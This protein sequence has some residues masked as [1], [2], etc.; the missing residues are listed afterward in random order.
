VQQNGVNGVEGLEGPN[1][2]LVSPDG[3]HVYVA[4]FG[5]DAVAV[6]ARD[7]ATGYLTYVQHQKRGVGGIQGLGSPFGL[8]M[9]PDRAGLYAVGSDSFSV[10][11]FARDTSTGALALVEEKF[12]GLDGVA[13]MQRPQRIAVSPDG[14]HVYVAGGTS[15]SVVVFSRDA[16]TGSLTFVEKQQDGV[17]GGAG[18]YIASAVAVSGDGKHVYACGFG[19]AVVVF[20]RNAATGALTWVESEHEGVGGVTGIAFCGSL[21]LSPDGQHVYAIGSIDK[22]LAVF[23]RDP[24]TGALTFVEADVRAPE[25]FPVNTVAESPDGVNLYATAGDAV[26]VFS[27]DRGARDDDQHVHDHLHVGN[28]HRAVCLHV[29]D[30]PEQQHDLDDTTR[31]W[32][33]AT[34]GVQA[35]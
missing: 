25:L 5:G 24:A 27:P 30:E 9:S 21:A 23:D 17:N 7:T 22:A 19:N 26:T 10:T 13:G 12:E 8:A 16:A 18:L 2:V 15:N 32:S 1:E 14:A 28:H 6:F 33:L 4:A 31:L 29:H 34:G 11:V 3:R 20:A 35:G